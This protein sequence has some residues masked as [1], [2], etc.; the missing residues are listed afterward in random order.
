[1]QPALS[2]A[3]TAQRSHV[4]APSHRG[5]RSMKAG[6]EVLLIEAPC[7]QAVRVSARLTEAGI[8]PR[9]LE[10]SRFVPEAQIGRPDVA[11]VVIDEANRTRNIE[12]LACMLDHLARE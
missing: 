6:A 1:M 3:C 7:E 4:T 5:P 10:Y 12:H 11:V 9:R 2:C 8:A